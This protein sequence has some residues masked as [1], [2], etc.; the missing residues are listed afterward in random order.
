MRQLIRLRRSHPAFRLQKEEEV[1]EHLSFMDGT[2]EVTASKLKN[3]AAIDPWNEIIV[4]HCPRLV[5]ASSLK[6][7]AI[8]SQN[9]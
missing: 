4:V 5:S 8:L 9:V 6:H 1:K 7:K 2:G 3:I